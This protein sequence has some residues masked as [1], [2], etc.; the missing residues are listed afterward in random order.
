MRIKPRNAFR[1]PETHKG[2]KNNIKVTAASHGF[3]VR[4]AG[5]EF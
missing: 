3:R 4:K 1:G 2:K 5:V